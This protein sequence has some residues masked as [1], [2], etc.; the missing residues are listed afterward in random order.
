MEVK[1]VFKTYE[2]LDIH[3]YFNYCGIS[4]VREYLKPTNKYSCNPMG[5]ANIRDGIALYKYHLLGHDSIGVI[6]DSD[7]DGLTSATL[8]YKYTKRY[9]TGIKVKFYLHDGKQRGLDDIKIYNQ[10][11]EDKPSLLIIPDAGSAKTGREQSIIDNGTD[12]L[13]LDHHNADSKDDDSENKSEYI[14]CGVLINNQLEENIGIDKCLSGCGVTYKFLKAMDA[15]LSIKYADNFIDLVGLSVLSDSMPLNDY[16]NR[17]YVDQ[18]LNRNITNRFLAEL[19]HQYA[20]KPVLTIRDINWMIVPKLNSVIRSEDMEM[21][22]SILKAL[23]EIKGTDYE[24]IAVKCDTFHKAQIEYVNKFIERNL[25]KAMINDNI[26]ML[27][28]EEIKRSYSGLVA[29][30]ISGRYNSKPTIVGKISDKDVVGSFRGKGINRLTLKKIDGFNW[31]RGHDTNA[32]GVSIDASKVD[33]VINAINKLDVD[34]TPVE[35]VLQT[36]SINSIPYSLYGEFDALNGIVGNGLLTTSFAIK[37]IEFTPKDLKILKKDTVKLTI[38]NVDILFF[39][40]TANKL[41]EIFGIILDEDGKVNYTN[42]DKCR[43]TIIGKLSK[44]TWRGRTTNQIIVDKYDIIKCNN[45]FE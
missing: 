31:C 23:C 33:D 44:N 10:I 36:L 20:D 16:E 8:V 15:E 45:Y 28:S 26:I 40:M 38:N 37:D 12:I 22:Q 30:A 18:L 25:D 34:Y 5:F 35:S 9:Y 1:N 43:A 11:M 42:N 24:G 21:K 17:Y 14:D 6:C 3:T 32:F 2:P 29:G 13:V 39:R 27:L 19:I 41:K 7:V 4:D